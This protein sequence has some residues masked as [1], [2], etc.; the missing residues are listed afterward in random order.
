MNYVIQEV[1]TRGSVQEMSG[2]LLNTYMP[3]W[4]CAEDE[5]V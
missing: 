5:A 1:R 2:Y 3:R 4:L